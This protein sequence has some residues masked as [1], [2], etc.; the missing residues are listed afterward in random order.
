MEKSTEDF[1]ATFSY[2]VVAFIIVN[3][4]GFFGNISVLYVYALRYP[5]CRFRCLVLAL[6]IVDFTSC[7]T[8]VPM[9]TVSTWYWFNPP[10]RL[11]C[12]AKNF[13]V[14]LT[15]LSAMYMLF[16][17]AVYKYRRICKPFGKQVSE[18]LIVVM[19]LFGIAI[20]MLFAAPAAI[21]W[22]LNKHRV[23]FGNVSEYILVCEVHEIHRDTYIPT[24]YRNLLS[25]F[26][27]FLLMTIILY[28]LVAR[29]VFLHFQRM[30]ALSKADG[31]V[32]KLTVFTTGLTVESTQQK[33]SSS[34]DRCR[35]EET[36]ET[37]SSSQGESVNMAVTR[38]RNANSSVSS[39][40]V[41]QLTP[42]HIRKILMM[43]IIAGTFSVTFVMGL[44]FGYVFAIRDYKDFSDVRELA[45]LFSCYRLYFINY[46]L[47]PV[48][49]FILDK[50]FRKKIISLFSCCR[51]IRATT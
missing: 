16:V 24:M 13:C 42:A 17:T 2:V 26:Y 5:R 23:E 22:D 47:N 1:Q 46:A 11:I 3:F 28:M 9:E 4:V 35:T 32:S 34:R 43:A 7:C 38:T 29:A 8:T 40:S 48:V 19:C 39:R 51:G 30:K 27:I 21:L 36:C 12:K 6:S 33:T 31:A 18:K 49:Y 45:L 41:S 14:Q 25:I 10:S 15:A 50:C 20:S 37:E 44:S